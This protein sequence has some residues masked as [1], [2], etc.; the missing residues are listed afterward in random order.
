MLGPLPPSLTAPS[1]YNKHPSSYESKTTHHFFQES[2]DASRTTYLVGRRCCAEEEAPGELAPWDDLFRLRGQHREEEW[3]EQEQRRYPRHGWA[4]CVSPALCSW[5]S[6]ARA[7]FIGWLVLG[8][9]F[10]SREKTG[11]P[12]AQLF[13]QIVPVV[14]LSDQRRPCLVDA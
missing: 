4:C 2:L 10:G 13:H 3:Q 9:Q 7:L 6:P 5:V 14:P 1:Y 11:N 8:R 12:H